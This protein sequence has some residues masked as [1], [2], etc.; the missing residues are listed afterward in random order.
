[1]VKMKE[2]LA[3]FHPNIVGLTGNY[4]SDKTCLSRGNSLQT[5]FGRI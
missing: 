4:I 1:M 5:K 2:Y 3:E